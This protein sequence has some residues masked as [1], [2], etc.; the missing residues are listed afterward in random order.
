M[1]LAANS[2]FIKVRAYSSSLQCFVNKMQ[3][4]KTFEMADHAIQFIKDFSG[5][6][7]MILC[8]IC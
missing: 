1:F 6:N 2:V 5:A 4:G 8:T 3:K 7:Y